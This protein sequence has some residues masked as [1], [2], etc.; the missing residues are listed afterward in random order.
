MVR[1]I[2][3]KMELTLMKFNSS[4]QKQNDLQWGPVCTNHSRYDD[5]KL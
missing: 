5:R 2:C 3:R 1:E 4:P